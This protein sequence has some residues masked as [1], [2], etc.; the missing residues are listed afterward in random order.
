MR[1]PKRINIICKELN[2]L[3]KKHS[4]QRLGQ[5]LENYVFFEGT[6]GDNTSIRL[7]HQE[8]SKT[9]KIIKEALK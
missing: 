8:D 6:R 4:D 9:L 3:W 1:D 5:L 7:Y 2:T